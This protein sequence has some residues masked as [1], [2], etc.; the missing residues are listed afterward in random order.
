VTQPTPEGTPKSRK[1]FGDWIGAICTGIT[2]AFSSETCFVIVVIWLV[3][4]YAFLFIDGYAKWNL[5]IGL[6]ANTN[7]SNVE[8]I[9]GVGSMVMIARLHRGTAPHQKKQRKETEALKAEVARMAAIL[10]HVHGDLQQPQRAEAAE[11]LHE[12]EK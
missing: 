5:G 6:F 7:G 2:N 8:L 11:V 4:L 3:V 9:T 12:D 10:H 1:T